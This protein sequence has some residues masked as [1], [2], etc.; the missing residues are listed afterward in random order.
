MESLT[1]ASGAPRRQPR[2][3]PTTH[4]GADRL[5]MTRIGEHDL[6]GR[7][8]LGCAGPPSFQ[9]YC[10]TVDAIRP[11]LDSQEWN[12]SVTGWYL[13]CIGAECAARLSYFTTTRDAVGQVLGDFLSAKRGAVSEIQPPQQPG[14]IKIADEYGGEEL[15]FRQFLSSYSPFGLEIMRADLL[16]AR[17]L[18][19]TLRCQ[20]FPENRPYRLHLEPTML[21]DSPAYVAL[22]LPERD[23]F[24]ADFQHWPNPPQVDWAHMFVNMILGFDFNEWFRNPQPS[25]TLEE[26][27][28]LLASQNRGFQI[29]SGWQP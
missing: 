29:P 14:P 22:S 23:R 7:F 12:R 21:R 27:N 19:I 17:C 13:N 3:W 15:R 20:L 11:L 9:T 5:R 4:D 8:F 10:Q 28:Q 1:L 26:I 2:A 25:R 18:C 24:W 6:F 16:H